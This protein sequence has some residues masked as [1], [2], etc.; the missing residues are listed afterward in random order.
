MNPATNFARCLTCDDAGL[1]DGCP[2]CARR[3]PAGRLPLD[4]ADRRLLHLCDHDGGHVVV[5]DD[6]LR[7]QRLAGLGLLELMPACFRTYQTTDAGLDRLT[8]T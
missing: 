3:T 1:P 7:A 8:T 5:D 2:R 4:D 6:V